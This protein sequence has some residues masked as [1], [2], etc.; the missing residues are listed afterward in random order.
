M[1]AL[2]Y[3]VGYR[4]VEQGPRVKTRGSVLRLDASLGNILLKA[5][6]VCRVFVVVL[7]GYRL[8]VVRVVVGVG[9]GVCGVE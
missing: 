5:P 7:C 3:E 1:Q 8:C 4:F 6:V 9:V 2:G